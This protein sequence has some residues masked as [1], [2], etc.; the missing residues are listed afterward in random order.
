MEDGKLGKYE[1]SGIL[2][3]GAMGTVYDAR[4]PVIDRRVAIKTLTL[5][6]ASDTEAQD[7]LARFKR[8]AQAAG[9][10]THPNIVGVFDYGETPKLAYIVMEFVDGPSLKSLLD[11]NERFPTAETVRIMEALLAGLQFSHERGVV[12]RDIKPANV[13]LTSQGQVKIADFGIARIESSS[14]TQAGTI[15]GT[16][17][18]MSP[19]QFMG[20]TVDARTDIYS[21]GVVLYQ[22]LTGERPFEGSMTA[23]MHKVLN[24]APP[25]PSELSVTTPETLDAV[26]ARA[27][28]K[29]PEQRFA[30]AIEFAVALR[31]ALDGGA[32]TPAADDAEATMVSAPP[33]AAAAIRPAPPHPAPPA[34]AVAP[35]KRNL[36][37]LLAGVSLLVL[38]GAGGSWF[39]FAGRAPTTTTTAAITPAPAPPPIPVP[40]PITSL[41][42]SGGTTTT[43]APDAASP[44]PAVAAPPVAP[45]TTPPAAAP[46]A[47]A[48]PTTAS[49]ATTPSIASPAPAPP[50]PVTP[51]IAAPIVPLPPP[52]PPSPARLRA[53]LQ[54]AA[55]GIP[56]AIIEGDVAQDGSV[57]LAGLAS[58]ASEAMARRVIGEAAGNA[59]IAWRLPTVDGRFCPTLDVIRQAVRPFGSTAPDVKFGLKSGPFKLHENDNV[60]PRFV[61]PDYAGYAQVSYITGDGTLVHL[62]PSN[63]ARHIDVITHDGRR[64]GIPVAAM[65]FRQFPAGATVYIADPVACGCKPEEIGWQVAEPYGTDMMVIAVSSQPLFPQRRPATDTA[66]TYLRDLQAAIEG[67]ARRGIRVNTR[68]VL[69][70]TEAR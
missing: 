26:V 14:M 18:Y 27:M 52:Q 50:A 70:E 3:K 30:S 25:R 36:A 64:Q 59:P 12:H 45:P 42:P 8:E 20:Q 40:A 48:P 24:V 28:A 61:M 46:P 60:V 23:I 49:P 38:A 35:A 1:I 4:D 19:E 34:V 66:E 57:T 9:R 51:Q 68:A 2:G 69:V 63:E 11:K 37:P 39:W 21:A 13:M 58:R 15:M 56:C 43:P 5:P 29:R 47:A 53:T 41:P 10:L 44:P 32:A 6:D 33:A 17:A 7:E 31:T 16:P 65:D 55:A 22:M 54:A 67:A 62:Y